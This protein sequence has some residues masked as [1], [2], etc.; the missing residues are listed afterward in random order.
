M[1]KPVLIAVTLNSFLYYL[2]DKVKL[3]LLDVLPKE[4]Y[5]M[6]CSKIDKSLCKINGASYSIRQALTV[7]AESERIALAV[8]LSS[9]GT[10]FDASFSYVPFL[11]LASSNENSIMRLVKK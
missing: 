9:L 4:F 2:R 3:S 8:G 11:T 5:Y 1:A 10:G 6:V 7:Y